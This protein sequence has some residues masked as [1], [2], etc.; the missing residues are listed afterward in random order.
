VCCSGASV[1]QCVAVCCIVVHVTDAR[2]SFFWYVCSSVVQRGVM[3][4]SVH[5]VLQCA[6]CVRHTLLACITNDNGLLT[7]SSW[8]LDDSLLSGIQYHHI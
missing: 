2:G 7:L 1:L 5:D 4:C 3:C 8:D 6:R